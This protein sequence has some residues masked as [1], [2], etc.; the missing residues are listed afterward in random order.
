MPHDRISKI[1]EFFPNN[2]LNQL[3]FKQVR[4]DGICHNGLLIASPEIPGGSE[5]D[6]MDDLPHVCAAA[7]SALSYSTV[8]RFFFCCFHANPHHHHHHAF[9]RSNSS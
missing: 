5:S 6:R 8:L 4:P 1:V 2:T 9:T 3:Q 7:L